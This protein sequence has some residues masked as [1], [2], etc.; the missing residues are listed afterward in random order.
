MC[1]NV[2]Q[3][4]RVISR[5]GRDVRVVAVLFFFALRELII[6]HTLYY[7]YQ[8]VINHTAPT[9]RLSAPLEALLIL[10]PSVLH[11]YR[12]KYLFIRPYQ[13][14]SFLIAHTR[15]CNKMLSRRIIPT[16]YELSF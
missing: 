9:E 2:N 8:S 6:Y 3:V 4:A 1:V 10:L 16:K 11:S 5:D 12:F 7:V 13:K 15:S 14:L